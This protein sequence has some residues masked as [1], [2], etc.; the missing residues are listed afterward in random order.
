MKIDLLDCTLRDG[1][2]IVESNFGTVPMKGIINHLQDA[3][4]NLI[5]VGWLK[6][7]P[8]KEGTSYYHVPA[9]AEQ[10]I[11]KKNT[12]A[13]YVA[14]ID[15]DRY[16]DTVLPPYDGKS[17]DAIRVVFPYGKHKGGI[18][19]GNRIKAKGYAV[20]YQAANTLAYR[21]ED[22]IEM[23]KDMNEANPA[24]LSM[25]DTFGA[26]YEEDVVRIASCLDASLNKEIKMGIHTHNNQQLAFANTL[27]FLRVM[28]N[29]DRGVMVDSSLCGMGRGA[30]NATT[31]L[32][33][34]YLNKQMNCHYNVD[35]IMDAIDVYMGYYQ[36]NY[37][38]GYSTPYCIAGMYCCHVNNIAYLL[39]NHRTSSK[40]MRLIIESLSP[41]DRKKYDYDLLEEKYL[42]NQSR[43][44]D[45][46]EA[47]AKV[48]AAL[49]NKNVLLVAPGKTSIVDKEKI[50]DYI[51]INNPIVVGINAVVPGYKYDYLF[52]VNPARYEYAKTSYP[53]L[54]R[55]TPKIILSNIKNIAD[56]GETI[57][58]FNS[59]IKRGWTHFDNAAICAFRLMDK[60]EVSNVAIAGFDG[61]QH[62]YNESYA[63]VYLPSLNP[64]N[65]WDELNE[66]IT[67]M[68]DDFKKNAS[69]CKNI[70]F[71]T[72]SL[73]NK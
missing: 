54:F 36:E 38:W 31:E 49:S 2:Y 73:F 29:S 35:A 61:F 70:Y 41:D 48:K 7:K 63:D 24:S 57:I 5:E 23:A 37:E 64:D 4:V 60:L 15:W 18:E 40:D 17:I 44:V 68:F 3:G 59:V 43:Y 69:T 10:Y 20:M 46:E 27:T 62:K 53:E 45:D 32:V 52:F 28:K 33:A 1:A 25:V 11:Q 51:C 58:G 16:D 9:D 8:H 65:K 12:N 71:V 21:N 56:E 50:Q 6:D 66:E 55:A 39:K 72:E 13:L 26:M 19:I 42:Q 47:I 14:M 30:G 34:N 22:L 67:E